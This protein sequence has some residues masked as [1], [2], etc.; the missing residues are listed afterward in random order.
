[1]ACQVQQAAMP[2]SEPTSNSVLLFALFGGAGLLLAVLLGA[3]AIWAMAPATDGLMIVVAPPWAGGA[4][5]VVAKAGGWS[6]GLDKAMFSVLATG[7]NAD[8]LR[9]HG[10]WAVFSSDLPPSFLCLQGAPS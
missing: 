2:M 6:V 9:A 10:A 4:E 1:M 3:T 5:A 7:T 8:A